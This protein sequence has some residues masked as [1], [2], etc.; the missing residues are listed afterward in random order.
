MSMDAQTW[1]DAAKALAGNPVWREFAEKLAGMARDAAEKHED[2]GKTP[3]Q[4]AE[5]LWAM[6][7]L[8]ELDGWLARETDRQKNKARGQ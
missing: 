2:A 5:Y 7:H 3:E 1:L 4:R 8:R 6:K